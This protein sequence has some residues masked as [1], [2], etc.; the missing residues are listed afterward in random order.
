VDN[1]V[2]NAINT[3]KNN[4]NSEI[5]NINN[6][7]N[8]DNVKI[9]SFLNEN[10]INIDKRLNEYKEKLYNGLYKIYE[11]VDFENLT[12]EDHD[13]LKKYT[14]IEVQNHFMNE[15]IQ[16]RFINNNNN[17]N[18]NI[19]IKNNVLNFKILKK[20]ID[21]L[22]LKLLN[23]DVNKIQL[24]EKEKID[25]FY[26]L[27]KYSNMDLYDIV[28]VM[29]CLIGN[30]IDVAEEDIKRYKED[31]KINDE[32]TS[33]EL[34]K[35]VKKDKIKKLITKVQD[36]RDYVDIKN[37]NNMHFMESNDVNIESITKNYNRNI[38]FDSSM[39]DNEGYVE[40]NNIDFIASN[41]YILS[42]QNGNKYET[43]LPQHNNV[44]LGENLNKRNIIKGYRY[45]N[46]K[47]K[48]INKLNVNG[49][50]KY[51]QKE[52][53][54]N[55]I[56]NNINDS[57]KN[58]RL[59][60]ML[61]K[62]NNLY[63]TVITEEDI[64]KNKFLEK[65]DIGKKY[66][67]TFL[68]DY[69]SND[70]DLWVNNVLKFS[71]VDIFLDAYE[72]NKLLNDLS[73]DLDNLNNGNIKMELYDTDKKYVNI[74]SEEY[75][76]QLLVTKESLDTSSDLYSVEKNEEF[77]NIL[78]KLEQGEDLDNNQID[79]ITS[80][81]L[82]N[83]D[84]LKDKIK[85]ELKKGLKQS[86]NVISLSNS[87]INTINDENIFPD[88]Q[89]NQLTEYIDK[90]NDQERNIKG[91]YKEDNLP[92][93]LKLKYKKDTF[94][95]NNKDN[96]FS[97]FGNVPIDFYN[98]EEYGGLGN[99]IIKFVEKTIDKLSINEKVKLK[100]ILLNGGCALNALEQFVPINNDGKTNGISYEKNHIGETY[101][102][103]KAK[104]AINKKSNGN[105]CDMGTIKYSENKNKNKRNDEKCR[106]IPKFIMD[107]EGEELLNDNKYSS[108][109][110][111]S[112]EVAF[113][114]V[115]AGKTNGS[116][117]KEY[118]KDGSL[119]PIKI[120]V[121]R[122][123]EEVELS[124][125]EIIPSL[126]NMEGEE[127]ENEFSKLYDMAIMQYLEHFETYYDENEDN[128]VYKE[129]LIETIKKENI[130]SHIIKP[131]NTKENGEIERFELTPEDINIHY[132]TD[133]ELDK[134]F[135]SFIYKSNENEI[136]NIDVNNDEDLS[137][138]FDKYWGNEASNEVSNYDQDTESLYKIMA[139]HCMKSIRCNEQFKK[140]NSDKLSFSIVHYT[141]ENKGNTVDNYSLIINN[142][143]TEKTIKAFT[144]TKDES[145]EYKFDELNEYMEYTLDDLNET[146]QSKNTHKTFIG[147]TEYVYKPGIGLIA[148]CEFEF[149]DFKG[150]V[151]TSDHYAINSDDT[152]ID[153]KNILKKYGVSNNG[154]YHMNLVKSEA[155]DININDDLS[156]KEIGKQLLSKRY[157]QNSNKYCK[158]SK[159]EINILNYYSN[160][161]LNSELYDKENGITHYENEKDFNSSF[162]KLSESVSL[163][164][165]I[166]TV[167]NHQ[168][169][170]LAENS[171]LR[172][173]G[174]NG[175]KCLKCMKVTKNF[176]VED[177]LIDSL[178]TLEKHDSENIKVKENEK[179]ISNPKD[180][181]KNTDTLTGVISA[182]LD[183]YENANTMNKEDSEKIIIKLHEF[184]NGLDYRYKNSKYL[185]HESIRNINKHDINSMVRLCNDMLKL[186]ESKFGKILD[187]KGRESVKIIESTFDI[188]PESKFVNDELH[189]VFNNVHDLLN[190]YNEDE[191]NINLVDDMDINNKS[192][193]EN[194]TKELKYLLKELK[195]IN[196]S[197]SKESKEKFK[198]DL[199]RI[200]DRMIELEKI[201]DKGNFNH[202]EFVNNSENVYK[203]TDG[204]V[205]KLNNDF[206]EDDEIKQRLK[207][208]KDNIN[209]IKKT[210]IKSTNI[211]NSDFLISQVNMEEYIFDDP[212]SKMYVKRYFDNI[213]NDIDDEL[214][215]EEHRAA[216]SK[217]TTIYNKIKEKIEL[218]KSYDKPDGHYEECYHLVELI[219]NYNELVFV[220]L[221]FNRDNDNINY[222][223]IS[224]DKELYN[225]LHHIRV[226]TRNKNENKIIK[227]NPDNF[228]LESHQKIEEVID[229]NEAEEFSFNGRSV[230]EGSNYAYR[231]V[232]NKNKIKS[233][234]EILE[235][236][237]ESSTSNQQLIGINESYNLGYKLSLNELSDYRNE[238]MVNSI[239]HLA[240]RKKVFKNIK[241][242]NTKYFETGKQTETRYKNNIISDGNLKNIDIESTT[243]DQLI[244]R[245]DDNESSGYLSDYQKVGV[246]KQIENA[247]IHE[248]NEIT[249][250]SGIS[251]I[252][253]YG[254]LNEG[255]N[256]FRTKSV[257]LLKKLSNNN[258]N[259]SY[260]NLNINKNLYSHNNAHV[261][262]IT[263]SSPIFKNPP[264]NKHIGNKTKRN[265]QDIK[266]L[267]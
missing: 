208:Y 91:E 139:I 242:N 223:Y 156:M 31:K 5:N 57:Q 136:I 26:I 162:N 217:I 233:N 118:D 142:D 203:L 15:F 46:E 161:L 116:L 14:K 267:Y 205:N 141:S 169:G 174:T 221:S 226:K 165:E 218:L 121:M 227:N 86:S 237:I 44:D 106:Y 61:T 29:N 202:D 78:I 72:K 7:L 152:I 186:H 10:G 11:K 184:V 151:I 50:A 89:Y 19:E 228:K 42:N 148:E 126:K 28:K 107:K 219:N 239:N 196:V 67:E 247:C 135:K 172:K 154:K 4:N 238:D 214:S 70:P 55:L 189:E 17:S 263:E 119:V 131:Y 40:D 41:G 43:F 24:E 222:I 113:V 94:N 257:Y 47:G 120:K 167:K 232:L 51:L 256:S 246:Q 1:V 103:V 13:K 77:K 195:K 53:I 59:Y 129:K 20:V 190:E 75:Y 211:L 253:S 68:Y 100:I 96:K 73:N 199:L 240:S 260:K 32:S 231:K 187:S 138:I 102:S 27:K 236:F 79:L 224:N 175:D 149:E 248:K 66:I 146:K 101:K 132:S 254:D 204:I 159:S 54:I 243:I 98:R 157:E 62:L 18:N 6:I 258:N 34:I 71:I 244:N 122:D 114:I 250:Y 85:N 95:N 229:K 21:I 52:N 56:V 110:K 39:V 192:N 115:A 105:S 198:S 170:C 220:E 206:S 178:N 84:N 182:S 64:N 9:E 16:N 183:S 33:E 145:N 215:D 104:G 255:Y 181:C 147:N 163:Q 117:A 63:N 225:R 30:E 266:Y 180:L 173:R 249:K 143:E 168:S 262:K 210:S 3:D 259:E 160:V 82:E 194:R 150:N 200:F 264:R 133:D 2:K 90:N 38:K 137:K 81:L 88:D 97:F 112:E 251:P 123:G 125:N 108:Y 109:E 216:I 144:I 201:F 99:H 134:T 155:L 111:F 176:G 76:I 58:T 48:D 124:I 153:D 92:N 69:N 252:N 127:L 235:A 8:D 171:S 230:Y 49:I 130:Y 265:I 65:S 185:D 164:N 213:K 241:N 245:V 12:E 23:D 179:S 37:K 45:E 128:L 197:G 83:F 74:L 212:K 177:S 191:T 193:K 207:L 261:S 158:L 36:V 80:C 35:D 60:D 166:K 234:T 22:E 93:A 188:D 140:G 209:G 25:I 87:I